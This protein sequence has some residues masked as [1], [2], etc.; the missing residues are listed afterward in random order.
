M[1]AKPE[2]SSRLYAP[3]PCK[4]SSRSRFLPAAQIRNIYNRLKK[5]APH[6][7]NRGPMS[8]SASSWPQRCTTT[9]FQK[10]CDDQIAS[11]AMTRNGL[12]MSWR[13]A[14]QACPREG[15][16]SN[17]DPGSSRNLR[18]AV[19]GPPRL[20]SWPLTYGFCG[21]DTRRFNAAP[22]MCPPTGRA[23]RGG[24]ESRHRPLR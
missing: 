22:P 5:C 6:I 9:A 24:D 21:L 4:S 13:A 11:P 15:T 17:L 1:G 2:I 18:N 7:V 23:D 12:I 10:S 3:A 20:C 19:L 16:G 14:Q 8:H